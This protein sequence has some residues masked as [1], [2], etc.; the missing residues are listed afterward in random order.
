MMKQLSK[1]QQKQIYQNLLRQQKTQAVAIV[2]NYGK[3]LSAQ[4]QKEAIILIMRAIN[5]TNN[6]NVETSPVIE[7]IQNLLNN[8]TTTAGLKNYTQQLYKNADRFN[9]VLSNTI[10]DGAKR[11]QEINPSFP[12][13]LQQD[14]TVYFAID[15]SLSAYQTIEQQIHQINQTLPAANRIR[16]NPETSKLEMDKQSFSVG[17]FF[18]RRKVELGNLLQS[19][20]IDF[21]DS[22]LMQIIGDADY[23]ALLELRKNRSLA[24]DKTNHNFIRIL[25]DKVLFHQLADLVFKQHTPDYQAKVTHALRSLSETYSRSSQTIDFSQKKGGISQ[26]TVSIDTLIVSKHPHLLATQSEYKNWRNCTSA[27]DFKHHYVSNGIAEGTIIVYGINS[28][29]PQKKI[30]RILLTPYKNEK[31]NVLYHVNRTYGEYNL[32]F[33]NAVE[34]L[35]AQISSKEQGIY[36]NNPHILS[37]YAPK[38]KYQFSNAEEFCKHQQLDYTKTANGHI[39]LETLDLSNSGFTAL[40]EFFSQM[41]VNELNLSF[42]P[43]GNFENCPKCQRLDVSHCDQLQ[44]DAGKTIPDSVKSLNARFSNFTGLGFSAASELEELNISNNDNLA[45]KDFLKNLPP[46]LKSLKANYT[47]L[48]SLKG[49]NAP[50]LQEFSY[51][52]CDI[53][54]ETADLDLAM[55]KAFHNQR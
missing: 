4:E 1:E 54:D 38:Q 41:E 20:D 32:A 19:K 26:D 22:R 21:K 10:N 47:N 39:K 2:K 45:D 34:Q 37:D 16:Y 9:A 36:K 11:R 8:H 14:S 53:K 3:N 31:G 52:G 40:P 35:A 24:K 15:N 43:L 7:D 49:L 28:H 48:S 12:E 23:A 6:Y 17:A 13:F 27:D 29:L 50:C 46:K 33:K 42:T 25:G 51:N 55:L 5:T 18:S 44:A 30:S